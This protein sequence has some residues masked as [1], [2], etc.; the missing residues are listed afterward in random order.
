[1]DKSHSEERAAC[2]PE[3]AVGQLWHDNDR[4]GRTIEV[5]HLIEDV[6]YYHVLTPWGGGEMK[7]HSA[8]SRKNKQFRGQAAGFTYLRE[9]RTSD[10][11]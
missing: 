5:V 1:V 11:N 7:K 6:V 9:V 4:L 2:Q 8:G 3:P 10:Y